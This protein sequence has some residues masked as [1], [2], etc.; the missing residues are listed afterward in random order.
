MNK[1]SRFR[2]K[3]EKLSWLAFRL[4]QAC[5]LTCATYEDDA[6]TCKNNDSINQKVKFSEFLLLWSIVLHMMMML[7]QF[8]LLVIAIPLKNVTVWMSFVQTLIMAVIHGINA[9]HVKNSLWISR[10]VVEGTVNPR[11]KKNLVVAFLCQ[12]VLLLTM[13]SSWLFG[14]NKLTTCGLL[15]GV[16]PRAVGT[17]YTTFMVYTAFSTLQDKLTDIQVRIREVEKKGLLPVVSA[18]KEV[19][20]TQDYDV[21]DTMWYC[22]FSI[23]FN[24]V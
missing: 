11:Y 8:E 18:V 19:I 15:F 10:L 22:Y 7:T 3:G 4:G 17:L 16:I 14:Y 2:N 5:G 9:A 24:M 20:E 6:K 21:V 23:K 12:A 1:T 13:K